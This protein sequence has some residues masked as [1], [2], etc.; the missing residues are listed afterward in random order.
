MRGDDYVF[1]V[2]FGVGAWGVY[3]LQMKPVVSQSYLLINILLDPHDRQLSSSPSAG[4]KRQLT[5]GVIVCHFRM[6]YGYVCLSDLLLDQGVQLRGG[7]QPPNRYYIWEV[8]ETE[9]NLITYFR[10]W[11]EDFGCFVTFLMIQNVTLKQRIFVQSIFI[12]LRTFEEV[13][14]Q[15]PSL[16]LS[17]YWLGLSLG[18]VEI[19]TWGHVLWLWGIVGTCS[20][21]QQDLCDI[22]HEYVY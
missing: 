5:I 8:G 13:C 6:R 10:V 19:G 7:Q 22:M 12:F 1:I 16:Y 21:Q 18:L 9:N 4:Y 14:G 3:S 20:A 11:D 17:P 15:V 2:L